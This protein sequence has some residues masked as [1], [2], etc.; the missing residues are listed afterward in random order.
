M[1]PLSPDSFAGTPLAGQVCCSW[2]HSFVTVRSSG[3]TAH[4]RMCQ[5]VMLLQGRLVTASSP[6][7]FWLAI[8]QR[9]ACIMAA[10][11]HG[12]DAADS[13]P[14]PRDASPRLPTG[15]CFRRCEAGIHHC[16]PCW[17]HTEQ[18][19]R[20]PLMQHELCAGAHGG[21]AADSASK[22]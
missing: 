21:D 3:R 1:Q 5:T 12:G 22:P 2:L 19:L 4:R 13:A 15:A 20:R 8:K 14:K 7:V 17:L 18:P 11:A 10:G 6:T 9:T 16:G